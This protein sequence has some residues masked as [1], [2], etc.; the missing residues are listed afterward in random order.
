MRT[1]GEKY[2]YGCLHNDDQQLDAQWNFSSPSVLFC[3]E[4]TVS[5]L[6]RLFRQKLT[7]EKTFVLTLLTFFLV[8]YLI[9][10]L[11]L[12]AVVKFL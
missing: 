8:V 3:V 7:K 1:R 6:F 10:G 9:S 2:F 11:L 4:Q 12:L 5:W